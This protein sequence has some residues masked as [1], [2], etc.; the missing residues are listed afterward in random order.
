MTE[1]DILALIRQDDWMMEVLRTA[2]KL[3][4]PDWMVGA[5]FVRNK[6]WN[7]L[8]GIDAGHSTDVDLVYFDQ[9]D[10]DEVT[11]EDEATETERRHQLRLSKM[12]AADWE[13]VNQA[14][15][16]V[17]HDDKP[18][19]STEDAIAH[20]PETA[21]CVAV[22]LNQQGELE[23]VAPHGIDDLVTLTVRPSPLHTNPEEVTARVAKKRWL[24]RWPK[25]Q[26]V[27]I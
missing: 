2:A 19:R 10:V 3:D 21:T 22:R 23:L 6:V 17:F 4:L 12:L 25:L 8:C 20:W 24:E 11:A 14:R 18:Y 16:H 27:G 7:H 13:A 26:V 5:G 15:M 9:D 1:D